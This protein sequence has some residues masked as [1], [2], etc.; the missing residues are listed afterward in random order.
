V[1]HHV[2]DVLRVDEV[3]HA[4]LSCQGRLLGVEVDPDDAAGADHPSPLDDVQADAAQ[5]EHRHGRPRLHLGGEDHGT[6]ARRHPAADVADL[7]EG[8]ILADTRQRD[9]REHGVLRERR[10][11][12]VVIDGLALMGEA[13]G[14]IGHQPPALGAANGL[15]EIGLGVQTVLALTT[16]RG[17]QRDDMIPRLERG[18]ALADL[19]HHAGPF[20][21]EHAWEQAFRVVAGERERIGVADTGRL[22]LDQHLP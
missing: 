11:A 5:T 20:V 15:T 14:A 21:A 16:L 22:E 1:C 17:I 6:D 7:L 2:V 19:H 12:H 4:E 8:R 9:L 3:G 10:A 18:H 13:A